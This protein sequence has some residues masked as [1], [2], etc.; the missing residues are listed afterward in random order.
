MLASV[1]LASSASPTQA[2][3]APVTPTVPTTGNAQ[4]AAVQATLAPTI[5][6]AD[7]NKTVCRQRETLGSRLR[8]T[9]ISRTQAQWRELD[10]AGRQKGK[11]ITD[12]AGAAP[13]DAR[14]GGG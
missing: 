10:A 14:M 7:D 12:R 5:T 6:G 3:V 9:R 13:N 11:S 4:V 2:N 8:P 1:A